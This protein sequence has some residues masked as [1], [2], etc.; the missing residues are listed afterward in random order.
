MEKIKNQYNF[1][2]LDK[3]GLIKNFNVMFHIND[4]AKPIFFKPRQVS[5]FKKTKIEEELKRLINADIIEPIRYS[6]WAAPIVAV[7][8]KNGNVRICAD[9]SVT[10]NPVLKADKYPIP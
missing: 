3:L 9:F 6:E 5:F 1:L 7:L 4:N 10:I 8:K 2:F